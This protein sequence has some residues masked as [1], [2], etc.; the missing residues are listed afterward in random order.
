[1]ICI[2]IY[3][4]LCYP[5]D[6]KHAHIYIIITITIIIYPNVPISRSNIFWPSLLRGATRHILLTSLEILSLLRA[7]WPDQ[8]TGP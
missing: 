6:N 1:M 5:F 8:K 4:I 2:Y 7:A 3:I